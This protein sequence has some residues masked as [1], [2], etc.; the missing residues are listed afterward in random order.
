MGDFALSGCRLRWEARGPIL[1][2]KVGGLPVLGD[3]FVG[4][5]ARSEAEQRLMCAIVADD[6]DLEP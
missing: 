2:N 1:L 3:P 5:D 6:L 4:L